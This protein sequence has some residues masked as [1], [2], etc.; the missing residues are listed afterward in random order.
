MRKVT[1]WVQ[2][3]RSHAK[4]NDAKAPTPLFFPFWH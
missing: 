3:D 1:V 2:A 4:Q